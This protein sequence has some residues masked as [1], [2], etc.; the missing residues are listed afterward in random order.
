MRVKKQSFLYGSAILVLSVIITKLIGAFFKIPLTNMLGGT[1]M[2]YF[3]CAYSI[4]MPVYAISVTGLPVAVAKLVSE[5]LAKGEYQKAYEI[6]KMSLKLFSVIG[7]IFMLAEV[8]FA[9]P[10]CKYVAKLPL[11]TPAVILIAPTIFIACITSV[12]RGYYEGLSNMYPTA[13]SQ[14]I[15]GIVK[16]IVGLF[17]AY[18]ILEIAQSNTETVNIISNMLNISNTTEEILPAISAAAAVMGITISSL[19]GMIFLVFRDKMSKKYIIG[20]NNSSKSIKK[21]LI[22]IAFPVAIGSLVTS[23]TTLADLGTITSSIERI[24]DKHPEYFAYLNLNRS[25][26]S[27]FFYGS[28]SGLAITVFNL[29][30]SVVNM[31]GK[32][33][34]PSLSEAKALNDNTKIRKCIEKA[35]LTASF[36]A[37]PSGFGISILSKE[38]LLFLFKEK[39]YEIAIS[40]NSL[41][42]L[43]IG[44]IFLSL[45]TTVFSMLQAVGRADIPLKIMIL[46]TIIKIFGNILLVPIPNININGAAVSTTI[47]YMIMLVIS[48]TSLLKETRVNI[49]KSAKIKILIISY[50]SILCALTAKILNTVLINHVSDRINLLLS[51]VLGGFIYLI[52]ISFIGYYAKSYIFSPKN[53]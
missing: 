32:G 11:A 4:F 16:I 6:K 31:F 9:Y 22:E 5:A 20:Q 18:K 25:E 17:L 38:I 21:S 34:F 19:C 15:E 41:S 7:I 46:G 10:F 39:T 42:I 50:S 27:G 53:K 1:G 23:L 2:G 14:T 13:V 40:Y 47:S 24:V 3:S 45:T 35:L 33:I 30:P 36:F 12:Y 49:E 8:L 37:I 26:I 29:V 51:I 43:G 44:V 48:I 28:F 52:L